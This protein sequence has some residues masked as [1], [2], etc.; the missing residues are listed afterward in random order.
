MLSERDPAEDIRSEPL[1]SVL[2]LQRLLPVD[3]GELEDS[4]LRPRGQQAEEVAE[5]PQRLDPVHLAAR[6]QR[7]EER[8]DASALVAAEEDPIFT[9]MRRSA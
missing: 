1:L 4:P 8:V 7:H 5:V 2:L 9:I 3:G 6:Q